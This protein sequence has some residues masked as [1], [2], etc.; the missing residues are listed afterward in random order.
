VK[1]SAPRPKVNGK[2]TE[3]RP[4]ATRGRKTEVEMVPKEKEGK[5]Y[6][7]RRG[8]VSCQQNSR[9]SAKEK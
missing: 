7:T 8:F 5:K 4:E 3:A 9:N 1:G 6:H 2:I